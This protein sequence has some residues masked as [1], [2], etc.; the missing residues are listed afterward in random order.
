[1]SATKLSLPGGYFNAYGG[2]VDELYYF[3]ASETTYRPYASVAEANAAVTAS[4]RSARTV[5]VAGKEYWW[6][7]ADTSD[8]GLVEKQSTGAAPDW[9]GT[10]VE[11]NSLVF[12]PA[13]GRIYRAMQAVPAGGLAP[14]TDTAELYYK[15]V[16][17]TN[18]PGFN[19]YDVTNALR[20]RVVQG[21]YNGVNELI[22]FQDAQG[23]LVEGQPAGSV[24]GMCF[25]FDIYDYHHKPGNSGQNA[26]SRNKRTSLGGGGSITTMFLV[27]ADGSQHGAITLSNSGQLLFNGGLINVSPAQ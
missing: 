8:T 22:R 4:L 20:V 15:L 13:D 1:M 16:G 11:K 19:P 21:T 26:W 24:L 7:P 25:G 9:I 23:T 17:G 12:D 27:S 6:Q 14:H 10:R 3:R 18:I 2:P 5:N